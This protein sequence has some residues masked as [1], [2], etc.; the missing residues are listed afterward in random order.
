MAV[1]KSQKIPS[2]TSLLT[3]DD[4]LARFC[5]QFPQYTLTEARKLPVKR[6]LAM[7]TVARKVHAEQMIDLLQIMAAVQSGKR[8]SV[9][10]VLS[11]FKHII[12]E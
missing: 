1:I 4:L 3:A 7:L 6:V 5:V 10:T 11:Y 8:A 12:E 2:T 9:D